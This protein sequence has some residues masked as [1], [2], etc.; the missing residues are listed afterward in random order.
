MSR[1]QAA[2]TLKRSWFEPGRWRHVGVTKL[3]Q[4]RNP[5]RNQGVSSFLWTLFRCRS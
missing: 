4:H 1:R 5:L 3:Q 2:T